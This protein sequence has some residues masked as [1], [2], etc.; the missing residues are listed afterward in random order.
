[1]GYTNLSEGRIRGNM[2]SKH[3]FWQALVFT[4][5]VFFLGIVLGFFIEARQSDS[6]TARLANSEINLLDEQLRE[7][8]ISG[9]STDCELARASMFSFADKIYSEAIQLED[10]DATGRLSDLSALHRRYDLLRTLLWIE[11]KNLKLR[12]G[13]QFHVVVYLYQYHN[14]DTDISSKQFFYSRLLADLKDAYPKEVILIPIAVDT[15][16]SSIELAIASKNITSFPAI[17]I[18]DSV[19]ITTVITLQDLEHTVSGN[20]NSTLIFNSI[21]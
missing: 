11:S 3:A 9:F 15:G 5:I 1:M 19:I 17:L 10:K 4:I 18:D 6:L 12:C 13:N 21:Q 7:R 14:E 8:V 16:L 2:D 20:G